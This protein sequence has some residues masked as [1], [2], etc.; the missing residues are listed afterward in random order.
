MPLPTDATV[1]GMRTRWHVLAVLA[2]IA[3]ACVGLSFMADDLRQR[4]LRAVGEV[5]AVVDGR[6]PGSV[7]VHIERYGL[8]TRWLV[9]DTA[10][11][12]NDARE[13]DEAQDVSRTQDCVG[14]VCYRVATTAL[15]VEASGDTG[16]TYSTAWEIAGETY[17]MLTE[18]YPQ[19]GNPAEHLSSRSVVVHAVA[20]GHV[21]FVANGRDG[22]L[23]RDVGGTWRRLGAPASGE[24]C[25]YYEPPLRVPSEPQ[26]LDLTSYAMVVV[27]LA[28]LLSGAITAMRRR[29]LRWTGTVAVIALAGLAGYGTRLAG[30]LPAS[31]MFPGFVCGVPII[32][33][34]IAGGVALAVR[35]VS[36]PAP[37]ASGSVNGP[38]APETTAP[39][40]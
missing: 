35:F 24:G 3:G 31:G 30:H 40:P 32:L 27:V 12:T 6:R 8:T 14:T 5:T 26:P 29:T 20:G 17:T 21:V 25:C 16:K 18:T 2:V 33:V 38:A 11:A 13:A 9:D 28:I 7:V 10:A 22:L 4:N 15:R 19:V 39:P 37:H 34:I 1:G 23:Y 36:G